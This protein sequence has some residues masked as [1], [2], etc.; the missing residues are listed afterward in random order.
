[1]A[2]NDCVPYATDGRE[3]RFS[4]L[5][6]YMHSGFM[7][8]QLPTQEKWQLRFTEAGFLNVE[9]IPIRLPGGRLFIATK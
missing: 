9:C 2:I 3:S 8:V 5:F 1:M 6:T 4:A 7:R